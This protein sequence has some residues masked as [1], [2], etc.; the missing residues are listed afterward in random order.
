[1]ELENIMLSELSQVQ[2]DESC[3]FSL[4]VED[5]SKCKYKHYHIY[6]Y[7][8]HVQ[9]WDCYRRLGEEGKKKRMIVNSTE[10]HCICVRTRHQNALKTVKQYRVGGKG[11]GRKTD[12]IGLIKYS[13]LTW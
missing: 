4:R 1:M 12:R 10:I 11:K 8:E 13:I 9:K 6:V 7:T 5:R 2:K 3:M